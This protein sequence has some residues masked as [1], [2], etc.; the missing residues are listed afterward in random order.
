MIFFPEEQQVLHTVA[1]Q[2]QIRQVPV[3]RHGQSEGA[4]LPVRNTAA[5][6]PSGSKTADLQRSRCT[7]NLISKSNSNI[8]SHDQCSKIQVPAVI[9]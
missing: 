7:G 4:L 5:L 3:S 9:L 6:S 1:V 2:R 8:C